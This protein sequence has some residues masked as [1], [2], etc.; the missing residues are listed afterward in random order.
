MYQSTDSQALYGETKTSDKLLWYGSYFFV[1]G[2]VL[3]SIIMSFVRLGESIENILFAFCLVAL[4]API[5]MLIRW[6]KSGE[7]E[8]RLIQI[9]IILAVNLV[10]LG[11]T[12][13][14]FIWKSYE[15]TE[16]VIAPPSGPS[17][18][19]NQFYD[20]ASGG[21]FDKCTPP[22]LYCFGTPLGCVDAGA[23]CEAG[24]GGRP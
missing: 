14:V 12:T 17:C 4:S 5:V 9:I 11:I 7:I 21:C 1:G 15:E 22:Q 2:F 18:G 24:G 13:Q 8:P 20:M 10:I 6:Y 19:A 23:R 16:E 3:I